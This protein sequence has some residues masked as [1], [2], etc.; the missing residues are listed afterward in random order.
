MSSDPANMDQAVARALRANLEGVQRQSDALHQAVADLVAA[1][2]STRASNA[3]PH[4]VRAQANA[5]SLAAI[6]EV[7]SKFITAS[8]TGR[9]RREYDEPVSA[10]ST[11]SIPE[12]AQPARPMPSIPAPMDRAT[13]EPAAIH[14]E[15]VADS[16][17]PD[18]RAHSWDSDP[19]AFQQESAE[20]APS[21]D[22]EIQFPEHEDHAAISARMD[23]H[24]AA[25]A[26]HG[27]DAMPMEAFSAAPEV[28]ISEPSNGDPVYDISSSE[29]EIS[30]DSAAPA[31]HERA[32]ASFE[33]SE[34]FD[35][36]AL[37]ADQQEMH[38][39]ANRVAKVS[40]QD[41][42]LLRPDEVK[43]GR[44]HR[45]ICI[46]LKD[47]IEKARREYERRFRPILG[48]GVDYF[49]HWMVEVLGAGDPETLGE[50]PYQSTAT[51]H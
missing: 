3:L 41:I 6:L 30:I 35:I 7:L 29:A 19:V 26:Q 23:E 18:H 5:A 17:H 47:E 40:M 16:A 1:C 38:R 8:A 42:Q 2:S 43:V 4:L 21:A 34:A 24:A 20:P 36:S 33:E 44:Q 11:A 9:Q 15:P 49:H 51:R 10:V 48:H 46:R 32:E 12:P 31:T 27:P 28:T 25:E 13:A 37:P 22:A 50:Y 39:R 14:H 45:D